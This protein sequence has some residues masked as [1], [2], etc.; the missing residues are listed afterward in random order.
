[1]GED[2]RLDRERPFRK[3][4]DD[5]LPVDISADREESPQVFGH[6]VR[7]GLARGG[8]ADAREQSDHAAARDRSGGGGAKPGVVARDSGTIVKLRG[9]QVSK[10]EKIGVMIDQH[11]TLEIFEKNVVEDNVGKQT[12]LSAA[13]PPRQEEVRKEPAKVA[14]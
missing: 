12:E 1:M 7:I 11:A 5:V 8:G 13:L 14:P 2:V 3:R 4:I 6:R 9:N 10:N